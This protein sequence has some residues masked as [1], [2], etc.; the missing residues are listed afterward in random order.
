MET[1]LIAYGL[2]SFIMLLSVEYIDS[3]VDHM[4]LHF[5]LIKWSAFGI[6]LQLTGNWT[7]KK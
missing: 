2:F 5:F 7:V 3:K 4:T 1:F 6:L